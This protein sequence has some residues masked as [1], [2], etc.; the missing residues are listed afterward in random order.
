MLK[1]SQDCELKYLRVATEHGVHSSVPRGGWFL[2]I[3]RRAKSQRSDTKALRFVKEQ[4]ESI[5]GE[6]V[7]S[8]RMHA[9]VM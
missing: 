4:Q 6:L 2:M 5:A 7:C 3:T 9:N 1:R 8:V